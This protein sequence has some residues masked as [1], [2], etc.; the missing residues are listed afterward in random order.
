MCA[1]ITDATTAA[2]LCNLDA[3]NFRD[4]I[5]KGSLRNAK[6]ETSRLVR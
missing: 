2:S 4:A 3:R 6:D 1:K 5:A